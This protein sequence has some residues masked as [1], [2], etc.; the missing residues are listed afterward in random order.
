[1][2]KMNFVST[3]KGEAMKTVNAAIQQMVIILIVI[4]LLPAGIKAHDSWS[5]GDHDEFNREELFQMLAPIALYPDSLISQILMASTY[6]QEVVEAGH[7]VQQNKGLDGNALD[8]ALL[9]KPWDPSIKS[10]CRFPDVLTGMSKNIDQTQRLGDAFLNQEED[11]MDTIQDLRRM[12]EAQGN[13]WTTD[14]Q[15]VIVD[16]EIIRIE[17]AYPQAV[18]VPLYNPLYVYGPWQYPAYPPYYWHYR[19]GVF[20]TGGFISFGPRVHIGFDLF[21]WSWFDWSRRH[22]YVDVHKAKRFHRMH[23]RHGSDRY[24]WKH[25]PRHRR[26]VAYR[27]RSTAERYPAT[28]IRTSAQ[29]TRPVYLPE[30]GNR[31]TIEPRP[32]HIERRGRTLPYPAAAE[33]TPVPGADYRRERTHDEKVTHQ[34]KRIRQHEEQRPESRLTQIRKQERQSSRPEVSN[35]GRRESENVR[36]ELKDKEHRKE[37]RSGRE[38]HSVDK[39]LNPYYD[40]SSRHDRA[41]ASKIRAESSQKNSRAEHGKKRMRDAKDSF[42][43]NSGYRSGRNNIHD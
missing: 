8:Y 19:P 30:N 33:R 11:V 40:R 10:L 32:D 3:T 1:M 20:I 15:I 39:N 43:N 35:Q 12:A 6:P 7:W 25:D 31:I 36:I 27:T 5:T 29:P 34:M 2:L 28:H 26:G 22:I 37:N 42:G 21:S 16:R 24:I 18:Y 14:E 4:L 41:S 38:I 23:N 9:E 13:L 17:P